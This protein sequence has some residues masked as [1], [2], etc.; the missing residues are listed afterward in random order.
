[1]QR[2]TRRPGAKM[3]FLTDI[4]S[5]YDALGFKCLARRFESRGLPGEAYEIVPR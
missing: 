5:P 1:M 4:V 2:D 3:R